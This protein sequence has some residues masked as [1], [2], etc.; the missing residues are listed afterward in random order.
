[1]VAIYLYQVATVLLTAGLYKSVQRN[2]KYFPEGHRLLPMRP[3]SMLAV[4][5]ILDVI[6]VLFQIAGQYL[7][8]SAQAA[9]LTGA[10]PMFSVGVSAPWNALT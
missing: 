8:A 5:L 2:A 10:E 7:A 4:F 1:M 6:F 9:D 3:R